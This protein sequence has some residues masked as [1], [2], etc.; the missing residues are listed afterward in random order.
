M[1]SNAEAAL[2]SGIASH[3]NRYVLEKGIL[4]EPSRVNGRRAFTAAD[5]KSIRRHFEQRRARQ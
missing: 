4:R 1:Y 3:R 5:I 2:A